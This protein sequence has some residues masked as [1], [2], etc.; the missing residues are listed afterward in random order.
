M[1]THR[2]PNARLLPN[3]LALLALAFLAASP[4]SAEYPDRIIKLVVPQAPGSAT[5]VLAR[6]IAS[7]LEPQIGQSIVVE[8][9]PGGALTTGMLFTAKAPPDG[10]TLAV[11]PI[12]ALAITRHLVKELPYVIERDF[13]PIALVARGQMLLA[14]SPKLPVKTVA[15][16]LAYAKA[17]PNTLVYASS[18]TGSPGHVGAELFK[19]MT[20][21]TI[22][23]VAYRGGAPALTDLIG[24]QVHLMME[25]LSSIAPLARS[26]E[27]RAL[28]V[29][30]ATR[31]PAFPDVPT[32]DEAGVKGY[33]A[34]TWSGIVGPTGIPRPVVDKLNTAVNKML[35]TASFKQRLSL[36]GQEP[37]GGSPEDFGKTIREDTV[38]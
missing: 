26:G 24:G 2:R 5:D 17:N 25:S 6:L 38:S 10:Y 7:E 3:C 27:V 11:G 13:Q 33:E 30:G 1:H 15:E 23:H 14:A 31:S 36:L 19:S 21:L 18:S 32:L 16:F 20:G 37:A 8:N 34:T 4:A 12:G 35:A 22:P 9:K 28:G 29:S